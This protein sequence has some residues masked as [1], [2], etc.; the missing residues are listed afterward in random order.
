M[1]VIPSCC[2]C[3]LELTLFLCF[4]N[5]GATDFKKILYGWPHLTFKPS[6][7]NKAPSL[8]FAYKYIPCFHFC[9]SS[10]VKR[11]VFTNSK[12][13]NF[14]THCGCYKLIYSFVKYWIFFCLILRKNCFT[15]RKYNRYILIK[16]KLSIT[17]EIKQLWTIVLFSNFEFLKFRDIFTTLFYNNWKNLIQCITNELNVS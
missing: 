3:I 5:K 15:P 9:Q 16:G 7:Q 6:C 17:F 14:R 13:E 10:S 11:R 1:G 4:M 2:R 12:M 8:P